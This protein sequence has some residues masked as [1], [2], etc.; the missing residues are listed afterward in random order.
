MLRESGASSDHNIPSA[1]GRM[2][3]RSQYWIA[4]FAGHDIEL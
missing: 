4:A 2:I 1:H 3:A